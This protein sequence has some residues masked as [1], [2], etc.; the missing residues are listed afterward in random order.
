MDDEVG[1]HGKHGEGGSDVAGEA[2]TC[3]P[4]KTG[5]DEGV[6]TTPKSMIS[7]TKIM[8]P[9][10]EIERMFYMHGVCGCTCMCVCPSRDKSQPGS[11]LGLSSVTHQCHDVGE[12]SPTSSCS[13]T[14]AHAQTHNTS[15]APALLRLWGQ[16]AYKRLRALAGHVTG[17]DRQI[18]R[19]KKA[20]SS[21]LCT[22]RLSPKH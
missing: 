2:T 8:I 11:I 17:V 21:C 13:Q 1:T 3:P 10:Q 12:A 6:K 5:G 15:S 22:M 7:S 18:K 20:F 16:S 4:F 9:C 14:L 19:I